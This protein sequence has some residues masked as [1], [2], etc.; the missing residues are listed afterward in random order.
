[1]RRV[2]AVVVNGRLLRREELDRRLAALP[3]R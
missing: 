3:G 2:R 1:V